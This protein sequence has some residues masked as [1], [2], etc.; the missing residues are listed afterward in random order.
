MLFE[1]GK[2]GT[3][4]TLVDSQ[5]FSLWLDQQPESKQRWLRSINYQ[6]KGL[7][8][9]ADAQGQ[10]SEVVFGV[11]GVDRHYACSDLATQLPPGQYRIEQAFETGVR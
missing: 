2:Q 7:C 9:I 10:L 4:I 11:D 8:L 6:G 5:Y 1:V 3:P